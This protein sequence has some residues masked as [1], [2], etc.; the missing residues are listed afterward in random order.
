[1]RFH[2]SYPLPETSS[3]TSHLKIDASEEI[4]P[5]LLDSLDLFSGAK[6]CEFQV[7]GRC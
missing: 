7:Y 2:G 5:F 1:M 6:S 4:S 3:S